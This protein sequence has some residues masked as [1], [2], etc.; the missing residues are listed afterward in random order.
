MMASIME[1]PLIGIMIM[2]MMILMITLMRAREAG[3]FVS[4]RM[5][6]WREPCKIASKSVSLE[7]WRESRL[8]SKE[9]WR[10]RTQ[11]GRKRQG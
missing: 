1:M 6:L 3:E 10:K 4:Y 8:Y 5:I 9:H 11:T 7:L 2:M